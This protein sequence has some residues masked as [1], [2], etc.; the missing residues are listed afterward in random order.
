MLS[1]PVKRRT[2]DQVGYEGFTQGGAGGP[3]PGG[4]AGGFQ[5]FQGGFPG[6]EDPFKMFEKM[7]GGGGQTTFSFSSSSSG[8]QGFPGGG[9]GGFGG[10]GFGGA[11]GGRRQPPQRRQQELYSSADGVAVLTA[12]AF[13][14]STRRNIWCI[15]C[16][17]VYLRYY[18]HM[19]LYTRRLVQFFSPSDS[20]SQRFRDAFLKVAMSVKQYEIKVGTVDCNKEEDLCAK[21]GVKT[22]PS[23][24]VYFDGGKSLPMKDE[25]P[26]S[27]K[28]LMQF[29]EETIPN[30]VANVR[31]QPQ[32]DELLAKA[33]G[34]RGIWGVLLLITDSYDPSMVL[35][36]AAIKFRQKVLVG[37]VR[38]SN[39]K[40]RK[41]LNISNAPALIFYC[42]GDKHA[43]ERY[44]GDLSDLKQ[45]SSFLNTF[46]SGERCRSLLKKAQ[47]SRS[48]RE[49]LA[50]QAKKLSEKDLSKKKVSELRG[51]LDELKIPTDSLLEKSDFVRAI[52][53]YQ[54]SSRHEL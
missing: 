44:G 30:E 36:A 53:A 8:G 49:Q 12:K 39:E 35:K 47:E 10:S 29:V 14:D 26:T 2:Y 28:G 5:G 4:S 23:F 21:E 19:V 54:K 32:L 24:Q 18:S 33:K 46:Q 51:I 11:G 43:F 6:G 16:L 7:F 31:L 1:D 3:P 20:K 15:C 9:F 22:F 34:T 13:K 42:G 41:Y 40:L 25:Q 37:E 17:T 45:I 48:Q 38:G 27:A 50:N 52:L